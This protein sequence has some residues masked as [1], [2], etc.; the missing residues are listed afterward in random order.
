MDKNISTLELYWAM[1]FTFYFGFFPTLK[2]LS[3]KYFDEIKS[4]RR[5][6]LSELELPLGFLIQLTSFFFRHKMTAVIAIATTR[7]S[8]LFCAPSGAFYFYTWMDLTIEYLWDF[9]LF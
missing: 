3:A 8:D 1:N 5:V 4:Y 7:V 6:L 2:T 9:H